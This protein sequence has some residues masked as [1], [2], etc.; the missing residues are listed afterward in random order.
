[1]RFTKNTD[2]LA[3]IRKNTSYKPKHI[4]I[5]YPKNTEQAKDTTIRRNINETIFRMVAEKKGDIEIEIYL[6]NL[7]PSYGEYIRKMISNYFA[8]LNI[9]TSKEIGEER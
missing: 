7:Y 2:G 6:T 3:R 8:K 4:E 9:K 5:C 1:M